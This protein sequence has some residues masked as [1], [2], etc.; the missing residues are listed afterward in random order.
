MF[1]FTFNVFFLY[2]LLAGC[3]TI[4]N[5]TPEDCRQIGV[6]IESIQ[7]GSSGDITFYDSQYS[8]TYY[9]NRGME[10]G[11]SIKDL[12]TVML[13]VPAQLW[14]V[15]NSRHI[16]QIAVGDSILYSEFTE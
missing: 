7:E 15:N 13:D 12:R 6:I 2:L 9:I 5:P 14:V 16:A 3:Q 8:N 10:Q 11:L 1:K 4:T